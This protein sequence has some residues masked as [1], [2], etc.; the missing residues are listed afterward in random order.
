MQKLELIE[1]D[2]LNEEIGNIIITKFLGKGVYSKVYLAYDKGNQNN[3]YAVKRISKRK[4]IKEHILNNIYNEKMILQN[5]DNEFIIKPLMVEQSEKKIY[6][7]FN[8]YK[9]GDL[10]FYLKF[11]NC[12]SEDITRFII[13]QVYFAL[14]YLHSKNIIYRDIKPEN[15]IIDDDGYI[16]LIDFGLA[17][18]LSE[19]NNK[20]FEICGTNE[21]IPPE[22]I[23]HNSYSYNFD[24]WGFGILAYELLIGRVYFLI[25]Y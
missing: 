12:F 6:I 3:L 7:F 19:E 2:L 13:I 5:L 1:K 8:Y 15:L 24:W 4:I 21:F 23:E 25:L 10:F 11:F 20:V 22:V 18:Q 16:K 9:Y 17:K 14:E